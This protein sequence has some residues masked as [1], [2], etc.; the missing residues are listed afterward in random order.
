M[1]RALAAI[2][3]TTSFVSTAGAQTR[4]EQNK[5]DLN[6]EWVDINGRHGSDVCHITSQGTIMGETSMSFHIGN[7]KHEYAAS[8]KGWARL[9]LNDKIIWEGKTLQYTFKNNVMTLKLS[10]GMTIRLHYPEV[11]TAK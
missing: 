3:V 8:D 6:C 7:R 1:L 4:L 5:E 10:D 9:I 11:D 2:L